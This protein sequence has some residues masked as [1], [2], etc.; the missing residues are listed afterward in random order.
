MRELPISTAAIPRETLI[1]AVGEPLDQQEVDRLIE[2]TIVMIKWAGGNGPY[3]YKVRREAG[4][5]YAATRS[6]GDFVGC[7]TGGF[8]S[9][10]YSHWCWVVT[11][12]LIDRVYV[13]AGEK[14]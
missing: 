12:A 9:A 2:G 4:Q 11:P 13:A 3:L 10:L 6:D 14:V 7:M 8:G 5:L 1:D